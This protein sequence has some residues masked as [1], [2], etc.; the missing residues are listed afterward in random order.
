MELSSLLVEYVM[1][2]GGGFRVCGGDFVELGKKKSEKIWSRI[3]ILILASPP[4]IQSKGIQT[5]TK[6]NSFIFLI[7]IIQ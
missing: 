1:W 4:M 6:A 5:N 7:K 3:T 2:D